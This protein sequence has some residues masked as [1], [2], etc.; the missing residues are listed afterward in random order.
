MLPVHST[1]RTEEV[2]RYGVKV[3]TVLSVVHVSVN[4]VV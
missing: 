4:V 3:V 2:V 1:R